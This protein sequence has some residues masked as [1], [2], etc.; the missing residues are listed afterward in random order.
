MRL[1]SIFTNFII[2]AVADLQAA[3]CLE[4]CL[5]DNLLFKDE[6]EN[7]KIFLMTAEKFSKALY[8]FLV[9]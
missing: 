9:L 5:S 3:R 6:V 1:K 8:E 2:D 4:N 7:R